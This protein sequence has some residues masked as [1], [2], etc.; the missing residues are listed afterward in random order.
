MELVDG[1]VVEAASWHLASELVRRHPK[2]IRLIRGHPGGGQYDLLWLLQQPRGGGD[3]CLNRHG[4]I[5]VHGRFDGREAI[6]WAPTGWDQ[7]LASDPKAFLLRLE[8]AAG[9]PSP[10]RASPA[11]ETTLTYRIL[12]EIAATAIGG[13]CHIDIQE[14]YIDTSGY[15]GGPNDVLGAFPIDQELLRVRDDD[16]FGE[17]GYRFWI[18]V[19]DGGPILAVE[20]T[21]GLVWTYGSIRPTNLMDLYRNC[22]HNVAA[23]TWALLSK[24]DGLL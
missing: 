17:P 24:V 1:A 22:H 23:T 2:S 12:A 20:Q 10:G 5:Q 3:V 4:S 7:Y 15:G 11:T 21:A 16:L 14:G 19:R 13:W 18:V 9:L 8:S 6:E